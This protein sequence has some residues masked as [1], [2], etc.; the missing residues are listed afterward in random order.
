ME[1]IAEP[2]STELPDF[3]KDTG[4]RMFYGKGEDL[5]FEPQVYF[6]HRPMTFRGVSA[7]GKYI[8]ASM[9]VRFGYSQHVHFIPVQM[10]EICPMSFYPV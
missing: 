2:L 4:V 9:N 10:I 7:D 3:L 5:H 8:G 6:K 1:T